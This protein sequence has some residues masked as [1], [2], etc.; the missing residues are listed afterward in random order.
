LS[1]V[2]T[3]VEEIH[4]ISLSVKDETEKTICQFTPSYEGL[5]PSRQNLSDGLNYHD[6]FR[7]IPENI[8]SKS[9]FKGR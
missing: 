5:Q 7:E 3:I 4:S 2:S 9:Y 1:K 8:L 6:Q